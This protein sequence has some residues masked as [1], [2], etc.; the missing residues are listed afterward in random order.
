MATVCRTVLAILRPSSADTWQ[1]CQAMMA[2]TITLSIHG[3]AW[4]DDEFVHL[5]AGFLRQL[6]DVPI[7][8]LSV[9]TERKLSAIL[10]MLESN[11]LKE[12]NNIVPDPER[13]NEYLIELMK[14]KSQAGAG[15]LKYSQN[16]LNCVR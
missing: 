2:G 9:A 16:V 11:L 7:E 13:K 3:L 12:V 6:I 5:D 15:M 8:K 10:E 1:E 14:K 4:N